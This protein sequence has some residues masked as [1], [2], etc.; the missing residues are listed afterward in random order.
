MREEARP[1]VFIAFGGLGNLLLMCLARKQSWFLSYAWNFA[2]MRTQTAPLSMHARHPYSDGGASYAHA[3]VLTGNLHACVHA[4]HPVSLRACDCLSDVVNHTLGRLVRRINCRVTSAIASMRT[5]GLTCS[6]PAEVTAAVDDKS[7]YAH[8]SLDP[9]ADLR[10]SNHAEEPST[11][12]STCLFASVHWNKRM[13]LHVRLLY[14]W[15]CVHETAASTILVGATHGSQ[16]PK[17]LDINA[18]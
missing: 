17:H 5:H 18:G 11:R 3:W 16:N 15:V 12:S 2:P 6:A 14:V 7:C 8:P 9:S 4:W 10:A 1:A 13:C